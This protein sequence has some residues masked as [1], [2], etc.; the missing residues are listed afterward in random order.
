MRTGKLCGLI[1]SLLL[2]MAVGCMNT[3]GVIRGQSPGAERAEGVQPAGGFH[4][5][6]SGS[7]QPIGCATCGP[8]S[9]RCDTCGDCSGHCGHRLGVRDNLRGLHEL[10]NG[11]GG[12]WAPT[13]HHWFSYE[14][15]RNLQYPAANVPPAV[16]VY[17]YYTHKGPDDFFYTGK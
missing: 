16:V 10:R 15:P 13:H 8:A 9:S 2:P 3:N 1:A 12:A 14:P 7:V 4:G 5:D 6:T 11:P 17:P